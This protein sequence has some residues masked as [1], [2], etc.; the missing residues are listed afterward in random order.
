MQYEKSPLLVRLINHLV[1]R[2]LLLS[3]LIYI[4]I[5]FGMYVLV[6]RVGVPKSYSYILVYI[7]AYA[8]DYFATLFLVFGGK[9]S[10]RKLIKFIIHTATFSLV[11][12][13]VFRMLLGF[14]VQYIV[15]TVVSA[16]AL[17]PVRYMSNKYIVYR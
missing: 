6:E 12:L 10:V 3:A 4:L 5:V 2:Y 1:L 8:V 15:A 13:L 7:I 17:M 9:S 14:K 16:V 11:G